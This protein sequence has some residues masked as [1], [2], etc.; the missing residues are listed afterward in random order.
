MHYIVVQEA[1]Y[2]AI[3]KC[4]AHAKSLHEV[5]SANFTQRLSLL[6]ITYLLELYIA[7]A[8]V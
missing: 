4:K 1:V 3:R 5:Y 2:K 8:A 7:A 6:K